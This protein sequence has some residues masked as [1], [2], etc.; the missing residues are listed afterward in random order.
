MKRVL[1]LLL[2]SCS[3]LLSQCKKA[4]D[5]AG[6][7][8]TGSYLIMNGD[9]RDLGAIPSAD[10]SMN[11]GAWK[12]P[13]QW[14]LSLGIKTAC[15]KIAGLNN[16]RLEVYVNIWDNKLIKSEYSLVPGNSAGGTA[17]P[18]GSASIGIRPFK[19]GGTGGLTFFD[20]QSGKI[21]ITKDNNGK[22]KTVSF[23]D[24]PLSPYNM[25]AYTISGRVEV[26]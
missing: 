7:S 15:L 1:L 25:Q 18:K 5:D 4:S 16:D 10:I 13:D 23:V 3:V 22:L 12:N 19:I 14:Q 11:N 9:K 8:D 17:G 2:M 6:L 24:I 21:A 20:A 26:Q